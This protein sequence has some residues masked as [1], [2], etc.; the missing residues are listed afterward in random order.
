MSRSVCSNGTLG[1]HP[2]ARFTSTG[3]RWAGTSGELT[4]DLTIR[5]ITR[6]V[7]LAVDYLGQVQDPWGAERIVLSATGKVDRGDW[8]IT[9]NMPLASGGLLVSKEIELH[10]EVEAILE[11]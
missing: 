11:K 10:L 2:T 7:T 9:W 3:V 5:G 1:A 8:G 6:P 4:G